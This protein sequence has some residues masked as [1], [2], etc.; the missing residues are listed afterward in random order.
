MWNNNIM[1]LDILSHI[2][3]LIDVYTYP[4]TWMQLRT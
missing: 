4:D 3:I 2:K 1:H